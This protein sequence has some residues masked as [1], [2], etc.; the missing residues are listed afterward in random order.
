MIKKKEKPQ[1]IVKLK[2]LKINLTKNKYKNTLFPSAELLDA[3]EIQRQNLI[4]EQILANFLERRLFPHRMPS[5]K[6]P[7][8]D[9]ILPTTPAPTT[10]ASFRNATGGEQQI[11]DDEEINYDHDIESLQNSESEH[12]DSFYEE[13]G[14]RDQ[15][16]SLGVF[17]CLF[18]LFYLWFLQLI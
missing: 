16:R 8:I 14:G 5:Q 4:T 7:S 17:F 11:Y 9:D 3:Q 15:G 2:F 10:S 13:Y 18:F 1:V 12:L 6:I